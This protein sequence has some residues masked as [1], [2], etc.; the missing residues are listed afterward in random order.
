MPRSVPCPSCGQ[1]FL[2]SGLRFHL[3][4][5]EKK[6]AVVITSC[7]YCHME[8]PRMALEGHI[9]TCKAARRA[10]DN[11]RRESNFRGNASAGEGFFSDESRAD[12][13][14]RCQFCG[15]FFSNHR[16][17]EHRAICSRLRQARPAGIGGVRTQLPGRVYNSAAART[18]LRGSFDRSRQRLFIP[19]AMAE[20][21]GVLVRCAGVARKIGSK[22]A[23]T[24]RPWTVL[25]VAR[26]A[27]K[28]EVKAAYR[29][30]AMEWHPDR[31]P[32]ARKAEAE[33][34]F[35]AINEAHEALTRPRRRLPPQKQLALVA[36]DTWR[37]KH[38][39]FVNAVRSGRGAPPIAL[40]P[41]GPGAR[42]ARLPLRDRSNAQEDGRVLCAHCGRRFGQQQAER[43]ISKCAT[44]VNK[45][46]P[47][48][49]LRPGPPEQP[50]SPMARSASASSRPNS[51]TRELVPGQ[52]ICI[53]GL[54]GA[55]HLNGATGVLCDFDRAT[56]R[57]HVKLDVD[58]ATK[59]VR[60]ENLRALTLGTSASAGAHAAAAGTPKAPGGHGGATGSRSRASSGGFGR[61]ATGEH[62]RRGS[63]P[64]VPAVGE[65]GAG[66]RG[67][68]LD[69]GS[70]VRL[71]GLTGAAHLNG[72][73]GVLR[74][75]SADAGRWL[76]EL[77][78]GE[79]KAVRAENLQPSVAAPSSPAPAA[80]TSKA[81][82]LRHC[83]RTIRG[84]KEIPILRATGA[85][86]PPV[87]RLP[88][89]GGSGGATAAVG[90]C[91]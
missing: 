16:V 60:A 84:G 29:R 37:A 62:V 20:S 5:C 90:L 11:R 2:P 27:S 30:L 36:P 83:S 13:H 17:E 25:G 39:G 74:D 52:P 7:S 61:P 46:K 31:H 26:H 41:S 42:G 10:Q 82:Q 3:K 8:L 85:R 21:H 79:T 86:L 1:M 72:S 51:R 64:G 38:A 56:E 70:A 58:A 45:A 69:Q 14:S 34:R 24:L 32:E 4:S 75:F 33:A 40:G 18:T 71:V 91:R 67:S 12:G 44:T 77:A 19:R 73:L 88:S 57:W 35:K 87:D 53:E 15:R 80:T 76:V 81:A 78:N 6:Q 66:A 43:H 22:A 63:P 68:L 28:E 48:P 49:R 59:A 55:A 9:A 54:S 65:A 47:P 89:G 50:H 23:A